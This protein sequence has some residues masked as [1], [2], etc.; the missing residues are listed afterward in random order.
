MSESITTC[1][2]CEH[3]DATE[4]VQNLAGLCTRRGN[5]FHGQFVPPWLHG[6]P[7]YSPDPD[8]AS[9]AILVELDRVLSGSDGRR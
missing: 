4:A 6:C 3:L 2:T 5:F 1:S 7:H 8:L 9:A